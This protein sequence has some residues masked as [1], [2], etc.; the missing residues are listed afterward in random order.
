MK[1]VKRI[2]YLLV[3]LISTSTMAQQ[4]G[5]GH[6]ILDKYNVFETGGKVYISCT[7]SSGNTCNGIDVFRSDDSLNFTNVGN[8]AGLCGSSSSP[9]TYDFVD[10]TPILNK[11]SYYK[12]ELGGYGY[13][14]VK[15]VTVIDTKVFGFQVRPNP[16]NEKAVI[17]Y[18]NDN[19]NEFEFVLYNLSGFQISSQISTTNKFDV[20]TAALTKGLYFFTIIKSSTQEKLIGKLVVQH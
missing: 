14:I 20:N 10:D 11:P 15:I 1:T 18:Q 13:T 6:P 5:P 2:F 4:E 3:L 12:L 7:I 8:V 16:A 19:N 9:V 17:Y